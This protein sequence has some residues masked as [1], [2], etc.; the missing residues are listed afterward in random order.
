MQKMKVAF[1]IST[2]LT[3]SITACTDNSAFVESEKYKNEE[4]VAYNSILNNIAD[5]TH[6]ST[7]GKT[8]VFFLFDSLTELDN[9]PTTDYESEKEYLEVRLER[10]SI[11]VEEIIGINKYKFIRATKYPKDALVGDTMHT[12]IQDTIK[13]KEDEYFT[14][15]WL[16]FSRV[17]FNRDYERGYLYFTFWCGNLCS[18]SDR[19]D[20]EKVDGKWRVKRRHQGP[21][22]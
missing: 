18:Q 15:R 13:L 3:V 1:F 10:R 12:I 4:I 8:A 16:T 6:Y 7:K 17:C 22:S 20:I 11:K 5:S 2:V 9:L 19:L 14:N 21:V